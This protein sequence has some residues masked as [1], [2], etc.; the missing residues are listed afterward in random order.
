MALQPAVAI[1]R[2]STPCDVTTLRRRIVRFPSCVVPLCRRHHAASYKYIIIYIILYTRG[3]DNVFYYKYSY[4][5]CI[6][7]MSAAAFR[8]DS[9]AAPPPPPPPPRLQCPSMALYVRTIW[10]SLLLF[11]RRPPQMKGNRIDKGKKCHFRFPL[12]H[13]RYFTTSRIVRRGIRP[14]AVISEQ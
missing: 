12:S 2:F 11:F 14:A 5:Y 13:K 9:A 1:P 4:Y 6:L 7:S 10:L 8:R 3:C